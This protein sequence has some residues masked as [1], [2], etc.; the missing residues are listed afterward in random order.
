MKK[1]NLALILGGAAVG[2]VVLAKSVASQRPIERITSGHRA[3]EEGELARGYAKFSSSPI[4]RPFVQSLAN[5]AL[6]GVNGAGKVLDIG[7]GPGMLAIELAKRAPSAQVMGIDPSDEMVSLAYGNVWHAPAEVRERVQFQ[8][9]SAELVPFPDKSF[10]L[11]VSTLA[12]H[13]VKEPIKMFNEVARVLKPNGRFMIYDSRRDMGDLTWF[14]LWLARNFAPKKVRET[15]EPL[16]SR[17]ASYTPAEVS[18]MA[19]QSDLPLW[20]VATGNY[21]LSLENM[22]SP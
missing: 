11:V 18:N 1:R 3:M 5:R 15:N 10:D 21:W 6:R 20:R 4:A 13:H 22:D 16:A 8:R 17:D 19:W 2:T 14:T 7:A 9:G 12:L